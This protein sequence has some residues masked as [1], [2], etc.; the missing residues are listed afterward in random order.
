MV[1]GIVVSEGVAYSLG[2]RSGIVGLAVK[3][4]GSGDVTAT[5]RLW[6]TRKGTNVPSPVFKNGYL[7][8]MNDNNETAFCAEGATGKIMYEERIARA[9]QIYASALL[10]DGR[11]YYVSRNGKT[12]VVAATPQFELLATNDLRDGSLFHATP[13]AANGN[14]F[15]RSDAFLYCIGTK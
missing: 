10:A 11:V 13:V 7:F 5:H 3:L 4:G 9:G 8:W 15:I 6:T 1:P 12:L 2:G 14:L